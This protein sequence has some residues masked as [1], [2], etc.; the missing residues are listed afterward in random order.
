[1]YTAVI[2]PPVIPLPPRYIP[3]FWH[4]IKNKQLY[5]LWT[6]SVLAAAHPQLSACVSHTQPIAHTAADWDSKSN[7]GISGQY[8]AT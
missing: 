2:Y 1:M 3:L 6:S 8:E 7:L 4:V 5:T